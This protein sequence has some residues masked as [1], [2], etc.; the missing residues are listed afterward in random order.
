M[1]S[2]K[3]KKFEQLKVW[4]ALFL[5]LPE[6]IVDDLQARIKNWIDE[7][8]SSQDWIDIKDKNPEH[9]QMVQ[10]ELKWPG[11]QLAY[12]ILVYGDFDDHD[13]ETADDRSEITHSIDV[14]R[15]RP[16]II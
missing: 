2:E 3:L 12:A 16:F 15:W 4:N 14:I 11:G 10:A 5:E 13:W 6:E 9:E 1:D 8:F 7:N